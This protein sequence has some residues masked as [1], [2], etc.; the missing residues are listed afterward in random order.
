MNSIEKFLIDKLILGD[1]MASQLFLTEPSVQ[2]LFFSTPRAACAVQKVFIAV[3]GSANKLNVKMLEQFLL[4]GLNIVEPNAS[5]IL[6]REMQACNITEV[7]GLNT[8]IQMQKLCIPNQKSLVDWS[9]IT[10]QQLNYTLPKAVA[11]LSANGVVDLLAHGA[12]PTAYGGKAVKALASAIANHSLNF[13]TGVSSYQTRKQDN[14]IRIAQAIM[15]KSKGNAIFKNLEQAT[16]LN[17]APLARLCPELVKEIYS[18]CNIDKLGFNVM[19]TLLNTNP[20]AF[21]VFRD[22]LSPDQKK[23]MYTNNDSMLLGAVA[24]RQELSPSYPVGLDKQTKK[25][26]MD[27]MLNNGANPEEAI[28]NPNLSNR[29]RDII[30]AIIANRK[31]D[32]PTESN[33]EIDIF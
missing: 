11:S 3:Y 22:C 12:D 18:Q 19:R 26:I 27:D 30:G 23:N 6:L 10:P 5:S 7:K 14:C 4:K 9:N 15:G 31:L 17:F 24:M 8:Q 33:Y 28:K 29:A 32:M 13:L 1:K 25:T 20:I 2:Q 21:E 16:I